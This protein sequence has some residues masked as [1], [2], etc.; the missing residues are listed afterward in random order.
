MTPR[1]V[2]PAD[3]LP[4]CDWMEEGATCA[5]HTSET[6]TEAKKLRAML[7]AAESDDGK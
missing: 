2:I 7:A 5:T 6:I 1:D 4:I 3:L